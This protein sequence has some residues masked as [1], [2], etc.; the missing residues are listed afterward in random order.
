VISARCEPGIAY[1]ITALL[2]VE[3]V[4]LS[5][6]FHDE[7]SSMTYEIDDILSHWRLPTEREAVKM[8]GLEITP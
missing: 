5:V 6:E 8:M 4:C 2:C 7:A 1:G 3:V